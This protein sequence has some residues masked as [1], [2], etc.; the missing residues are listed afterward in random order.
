[1]N[2]L[3]YKGSSE[4]RFRYMGVYMRKIK[5]ILKRGISVGLVLTLIMVSTA[6]GKED[7]VV[8]DYGEG[9]EVDSS[10]TKSRALRDIY[11]ET[12]TTEE[13]F[14]VNGVNVKFNLNYQVPDAKQ[15]NVYEGSLL[16]NG[17]DTEKQIVNNFFGGTEKNLEEIKYVNESDYM[18]LLEKYRSLL[19]YQEIEG[20]TNNITQD[21]SDDYSA[22][23]DS[24]FDK[25]YKWVDEDSYYIHMYEGEYEGNRY[26]MIYSY[27]KVRAKRN[28]FISPI[29]ISEYYPEAELDSLFIVDKQFDSEMD[30]KCSMTKTDATNA[31]TDVVEKLGL[32]TDDIEI[33]F[34]P[35]Y[36][37]PKLVMP[38]VYSNYTVEETYDEMPRLIFSDSEILSTSAK[39][40]T[41]T[42]NFV[43][44]DYQIL[45]EQVYMAS[46]DDHV[47]PEDIN[48]I[49][50][51]Y[52]LYLY[53]A[54]FSEG[55]TPVSDSSFN[56]GS[57]LFTDKGLYTVD[58][59]L[60]AD[61]DKVDEGVPLISFDNI[62]E[63]YKKAL[64]NDPVIINKASGSI[65]VMSATFTYVL[66]E[67]GDNID[68]ATYVPAWCFKSSD[69]QIKSG[70]IPVV[71]THVI[72]AIDGSD[73]S[74]SLK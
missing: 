50:D 41:N 42:Q 30:N 58:I 12:I 11:G 71:Y 28:I 55:V 8:S 4:D 38:V 33:C 20:D 10:D 18:L 2:F 64:E 21:L 13:T 45:K 54:P 44:Y 7:K 37:I 46:H 40:Y 66:I 52:A 26:G 59:S 67:D 70:E 24:S 73:L 14:D 35:N 68:K 53:S 61:I 19:F 3:F 27:D 69:D 65:D 32:K 39:M 16:E 5:S 72:N 62:K 57:I 43:M 48:L 60:I 15:A 47:A 29:S 1:M 51:G 6:C 49:E 34:N 63:G 56:R 36:D 74:G 25:V 23:I 17:A 9:T 31:A 22:S